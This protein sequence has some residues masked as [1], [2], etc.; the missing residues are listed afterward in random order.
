MPL[1]NSTQ[2]ESF[3]VTKKLFTFACS[4]VSS[5]DKDFWATFSKLHHAIFIDENVN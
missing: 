1:V 4:D 5:V 3:K 2:F